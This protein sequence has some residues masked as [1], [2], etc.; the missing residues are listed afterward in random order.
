[1][2]TFHASPNGKR[3]LQTRFSVI[4]GDAESVG[5]D[6]S[7][8]QLPEALAELERV[9]TRLMLR[10]TTVGTRSAAVEEDKLLTV[11][12]AAKRLALAPDTLYRKAKD[13]P[14]TVRIGHQLRFSS[15]GIDKFIRSRQGRS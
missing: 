9:R 2:S 11:E 12:V 10:L 4:L 3:P 8:E 1:M 6:L 5:C 14:F 7:P 13:L 15:A